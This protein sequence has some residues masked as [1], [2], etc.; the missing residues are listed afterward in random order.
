MKFKLS[1]NNISGLQFFQLFRFSILFLISIILSKS[2][3]GTGEIGIY[4]TFLLIAGG[5]SF[6]WIGGLIQS[7]L[8]LFKSNKSFTS[9]S[10][11]KTP[12]LFNSFLLMLFFSVLAGLFVF[13][14]DEVIA[15]FLSLHTSKIPYLK[16]LIAY[17]VLSGPNNL[18]EYI[19]L[20]KNHPKTIIGYG[21]ISFTLQLFFVTV[22]VLLGYDLGYGLYGLVAV[23]LL[24][25]TY[26]IYLLFKY[27]HFKFSFQFIK[28]HLG[29][30]TPL[31]FSIFLSGSASYVDGFLVSNK[32]SEAT[33]A[34]F[35]YGAR[36]LPF[37]VLLANAFSN[38]MIPEFSGQSNLSESLNLLKR[39]SKKL[40][41]YLFPASIVLLL[42][43]NWLYPLIFNP[44][45]AE[46]AN[47]F[48]IYLL[49][50]VS[51]LIFPQTILVGL[52]KTRII[53][54]SSLFELIINIGLSLVLINWLGIEGVALATLIAYLIQKIIMMAYLSIQENIKL[55]TYTPITTWITWSVTIS[56]VYLI[57]R[58][59]FNPGM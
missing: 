14:S 44:N 47:V 16:I 27:S 25:F 22:P 34:I 12:I 53:M 42:I 39:R 59:I 24:K 49:I 35:R 19:L 29:L 57:V 32:F 46:S 20:L 30:A 18:I 15:G 38:A 13:I 45:F 17:I 58:F 8:P 4:E 51:R 9:S 23:N 48:N 7:I 54:F 11:Q 52:K 36:E 21:I 6:F 5:V 56:A 40:M 1:I 10:T 28:E 37:V 50:I 26:L 33:F 55:A 2:Q 43:S 41:H 31:I 3:L